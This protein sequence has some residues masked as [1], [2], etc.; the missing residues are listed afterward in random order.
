[1]NDKIYPSKLS[2]LSATLL[3]PLW[4]KAIEYG[5][6]DALLED[7][8]AVRMMKL[9]NYDFDKFSSA[10]LSQIGCCGRARLIDNETRRFIERYPDSVVLQLGAGLDARF[11]RLGRPNVTWFDLDLPEVIA[12]RRQL[13]PES[14]NRYLATSLFDE[15][16]MRFVAELHKP[17][18][19]LLEGVLMYFPEAEVKAFFATV[20]RHLPRATVVFDILPPVAVGKSKHHDALKK[21]NNEARPEF[22][23]ALEDVK[24][25]LSWQPNLRLGELFYLSQHVGKRYPCWVRLFYSTACGRR[26]YD[27]RIVRLELG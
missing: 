10:K 21:M 2:G 23:W 26:K 15:S 3:I 20:A 24:T 17:V 12:I 19:L 25:M 9:I 22:K 27:M 1:M 5:R 11:E 18:L 4:A 13:L 8:E 7:L 14:K 6:P 16:W